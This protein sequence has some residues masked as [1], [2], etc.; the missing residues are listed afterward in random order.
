MEKLHQKI[1][2]LALKYQDTRNDKGHGQIVTEFA[3]KICE[4]EELNKNVVVP[5][6]IL[7]DIGWSQLNKEDRMYCFQQDRDPEKMFQ[8]RLVHQQESVRLGE[9]ILH[10]VKYTEEN[11]DEILEIISQHDTRTD[12]ISKNEAALRDADKLWRFSKNGFNDDVKKSKITPEYYCEK[13]SKDLELPNYMY[14]D[15]ARKIARIELEKRNE[16]I[17]S[18]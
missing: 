9:E 2:D 6:A 15:S 7:H 3:E 5:A 1:W 18:Q 13:L 17:L 11:I 16:E 10:K 4:M 12:F 14:F 8:I